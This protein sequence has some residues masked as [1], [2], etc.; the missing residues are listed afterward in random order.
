[1]CCILSLCSITLL[2]RQKHLTTLIQ[3]SRVPTHVL[4]LT[5]TH[6]Q[7]RPRVPG[8]AT[9]KRAFGQSV[10]STSAAL[11]PKPW[12]PLTL[13][14][15]ALAHSLPPF[16]PFLSSSCRDTAGLGVL[17]PLD[18]ADKLYSLLLADPQQSDKRQPLTPTRN[19][20]KQVGRLPARELDLDGGRGGLVGKYLMACDIISRLWDR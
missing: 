3:T 5:H 13:K 15:D 19:Q 2:K 20:R 8:Q 12:I 4:T 16:F 11:G 14:Y 17:V 10:H 1:M 7:L 9:K 18:I 6:T